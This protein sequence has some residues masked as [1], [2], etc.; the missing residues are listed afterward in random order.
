MVMPRT[1]FVSGD[2]NAICDVCGFRY[3][4]SQLRKRWDGLMVCTHDWEPR[5]PQDFIKPIKE[6]IGV[7]WT[8]PNP[9]PVFVNVC[10]LT[11]VNALPGLGTG[12]CMIAGST[13][14]YSADLFPSTFNMNTL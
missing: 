6:R 13:N 14:G 4:A 1:W 12:G 3:K 2:W 10:S 7:P 11:A 5:H 9:E 8:R